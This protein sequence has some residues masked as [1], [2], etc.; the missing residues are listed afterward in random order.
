VVVTA[1]TAAV[2]ARTVETVEPSASWVMLVVSP[3]P[4]LDDRDDANA[5]SDKPLTLADDAPADG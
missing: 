5:A 2:G 4:A 1:I 3:D